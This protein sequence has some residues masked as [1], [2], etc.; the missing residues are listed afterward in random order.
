MQLPWQQ[1]LQAFAVARLWTLLSHCS[2]ASLWRLSR[3]LV[4]LAYP[5][6]KRERAVTRLNLEVVYPDAS[7]QQRES[8]ARDSLTHSTATML[9]LGFSWQGDP[10]RVAD[11]IVEVHGRALLDDARA[12]G[13]GVIILAPHFGNWEVLNFWLSSHFPFT[14][15][16][17]P[18]KLA[19]LDPII[20]AGRERCG[21]SLVPTNPRGVA[22]L[23]KALK[24]CEAVGILP[25]QEPSWG[26]G[27]FAPFFGRPAYTATLLPKL[28]GRT[29]A[30]V[31]TGVALRLPGRG[32]ALHF[33]AA[34]ERV[35][36]ADETTSCTG[37][38]AS[39]EEVIA[40]EPAQYQWEYKRFTKT[41]EEQRGDPDFRRHRLYS[42]RNMK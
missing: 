10:Q 4:S 19:P 23:L 8:L 37:V 15:M 32:F 33:L 20:R 34:D 35:Y 6:L 39:I 42:S 27:V 40:L 3:V 18:P 7:P 2:P 25:D 5:L 1:R 38:N 9:E 22:A 11:S 41:L 13:K 17:E 29:E 12:E 26:S 21:A 14:A 30:R 36:D 28:V 31:V 24:R 16:Y